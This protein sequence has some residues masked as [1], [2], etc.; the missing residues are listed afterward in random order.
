MNSI[1]IVAHR[2]N[3][4]EFPENTMAAFRS[5]ADIGARMIELDVHLSKDGQAVVMHDETLD[6]T[7]NGH[8]A[9]ADFTV[10][11]L[12]GYE[13]GSGERI[14]LLGEVLTLPI[15]INVEIKSTAAAREVVRL[16]A[17][18]SDIVVSSFDF[19]ALEVVRAEAPDLPI[20]YLCTA[21]NG[22]D[23]LSHA[24]A[25]KAFS[26]N[27]PRSIVTADLLNRAHEAGLKVW[28]Y[29]IND[30]LEAKRL[31]ALGLDALFTDNPRLML[32]AFPA[33][34]W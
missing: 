5:A 25:A 8:G 30:E 22:A 18:R 13:A 23:A 7:T 4:A 24:R 16:V 9:I 34:N 28:S 29:T 15:A 3:S 27:P 33:A 12:A 26:L 11:Q 6:R 19:S 17:G 14:P 21:N 10:A 2:G 31:F 32:A 20:A 1:R